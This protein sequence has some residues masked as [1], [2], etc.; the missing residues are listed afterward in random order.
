MLSYVYQADHLRME[1]LQQMHR[2]LTVRQAARG[3]LV[4]G[5]YFQR[6]KALSSLWADRRRDSHEPT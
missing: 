6:L 1:T 2:I 4:L 5:E 3:L